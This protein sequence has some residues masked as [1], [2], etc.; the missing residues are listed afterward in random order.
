MSPRC[1]TGCVQ[2]D[3]RAYHTFGTNMHLSCVKI[4]TISKQTKTSIHLSLVTSEYH[5]VRPKWFSEPMVR[6]AQTVH[7]SAPTLTLSSNE[8]KLDSKWPTSPR[9]SIGC[10]QN[11]FRACDTF[12]ANR[13]PI[14]QQD[15]H[16]LL[17]ERN[18]HPLEL[19]HPGGPSGSSNT[20]SEPMVRLA[21]TVHLSC[22]TLTLSPNGQKWDSTWPTSPS[23][24]IRCVQNNFWAYGMFDT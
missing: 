6:F 20:I 17:T 4:S 8:P 22:T 19:G 14:L 11:N 3:F 5:P 18:K 24:S 21:Q 23:R 16:Y 9:S 13:A 1:S 2:N 15:L 7:L 10:V 12:G